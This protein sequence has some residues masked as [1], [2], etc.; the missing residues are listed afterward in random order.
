M[1][2]TEAISARRNVVWD[3][4]KCVAIFCVIAGHCFQHTGYGNA[5]LNIPIFRVITMFEIPLFIFLSGCASYRSFSR[6]SPREFATKRIRGILMPMVIFATIKFIINGI[7][8]HRGAISIGGALHDLLAEVAYGYWFIWVLLYCSFL[9]YTAFKIGGNY[10]MLIAYI[11]VMLI[12]R[13]LPL[14]HLTSF[15]AML[16]FFIGGVLFSRYRVSEWLVKH[17]MTI[18]IICLAAVVGCYVTYRACGVFYFF[19]YMPTYEYIKYYA[20]LLV[21]GTATIALLYIAAEGIAKHFDSSAIVKRGAHIGQL[22]LGIYLIQDLFVEVAQKYDINI[23]QPTLQLL[24]S[25]AV[26]AVSVAIVKLISKS[27]KLSRV[28]IGK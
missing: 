10:G 27:R 1:T 26:F 22:T 15:Q 8:Y 28:M 20:H 2:A 17:K 13:S 3:L 24:L 6:T 23:S 18:G 9:T 19:R 25:V 16:P 4:L 7:I 5:Y 12:P 14:P 21:A 11:A